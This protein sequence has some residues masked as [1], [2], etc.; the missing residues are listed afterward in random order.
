MAAQ[1]GGEQVVFDIE[2]I[3]PNPRT[4]PDRKLEVLRRFL[5]SEYTRILAQVLDELQRMPDCVDS[6]TAPSS[7]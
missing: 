7:S 1:P 4:S 5:R 2:K 3:D 6:E